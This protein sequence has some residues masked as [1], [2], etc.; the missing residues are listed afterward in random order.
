[1]KRYLP[2]PP[3]PYRLP[4]RIPDFHAVPA[5][6]RRDGW[7]PLRQAEFI[8]HLAATRSVSAAAKAVSMA[9]ESAYRLRT[10]RWAEEFCA[11]WDAALGNKSH[12][13]V[14]FSRKV[15]LAE[16]QWRIESGLWRVRLVQGRY[17]GV[18]HKA[19]NSAL[20]SLLARL[21][22]GAKGRPADGGGG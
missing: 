12:G 21:N 15:T 3:R 7:T 22:Y 1:M 20:L 14:T 5:R 16:L 8:G 13:S 4:L 19:D 11:A 17:A 6:A 10:R 9:R 2:R 18:L